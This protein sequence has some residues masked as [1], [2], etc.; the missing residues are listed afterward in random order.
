MTQRRYSEAEEQVIVDALQTDWG[1]EKLR[2]A[3]RA[4]SA[5]AADRLPERSLARAFARTL[6]GLP[7]EP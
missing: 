3:I 7:E 4:A 1:R 5:K 6:A 2:D